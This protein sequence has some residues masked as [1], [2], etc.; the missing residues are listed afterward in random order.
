MTVIHSPESRGLAERVANSLGRVPSLPG[1]PPAAS[2]DVTVVLAPDERAFQEA[3]GARVPEWG[4]GVALPTEGRI[5]LP[6]YASNRSRGRDLDALVRHEWAHVALGRYLDGLRIPNWFHEGYAEWA[7][8]QFDASEG[9]RLR[10]LLALRRAPPFDSLSLDW[11]GDRA[12]AEVAYLLSASAVEYLARSSGPTGLAT[13][14]ASWREGGGFESAFR[15]T[16]GVTTAQFEEDWTAY[17]KGRYGWLLVLSHS[18]VFWTITVVVLVLL[19]WIRRRRT[20]DH[21]ARMRA[22]DPPEA[23]AY[24]ADAP[25]RGPPWGPPGGP[26]AAP[27]GGP[28]TAPTGPP[29]DVRAGPNTSDDGG[30]FGD[31]PSEEATGSDSPRT[32]A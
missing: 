28:P 4:A 3:V 20:R 1:L 11:P 31:G 10:V 30:Y 9:W 29:T 5:V 21:L 15:A 12:S 25:P 2:L 13:F 27:T 24:W 18:L 23:P 26:P 8:G 17:V 14:L 32:R 16:F 22:G 7:S 6:A 19:V